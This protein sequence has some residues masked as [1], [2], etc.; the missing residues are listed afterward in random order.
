MKYGFKKF[1]NQI[2][3]IGSEMVHVKTE[4]KNRVYVLLVHKIGY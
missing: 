3:S 4:F 2:I 1:L